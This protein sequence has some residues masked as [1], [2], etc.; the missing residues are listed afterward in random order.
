MDALGLLLAEVDEKRDNIHT[1]L[2]SGSVKDYA[3]YRYLCGILRGIL[4]LAEYVKSL[5]ERLD[6]DE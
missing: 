5:Q 2:G 6:N 1:K 3:E 4:D